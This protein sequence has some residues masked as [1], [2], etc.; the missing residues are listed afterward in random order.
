MRGYLRPTKSRRTTPAVSTV[1]NSAPIATIF[2]R[3][4]SR[5]PTIGAAVGGLT[6]YLAGGD[7][8]STLFGAGAGAVTGAVG[9]YFIAKQKAANGNPTA[10]ADSVYD[11]LNNENSEIDG[12]TG[13]FEKLRDCRLDAARSVKDDLAAHRISRDD[14]QAKLKKIHDWLIE[15][16]DFADALGAKMN[17]RGAAYADASD[18]LSESEPSAKRTLHTRQRTAGRSGSAGAGELVA[19]AAA[20]VREGPS[21]SSRQIASLAPGGAVAT[22]GG[23]DT[24]EGWTHVRL[25]DG[26]S[27]YIASRLLHEAGAG[28]AG[29]PP[30]K[31][32]AGVAQLTESNQLKRKALTEDVADAKSD[33]NG[34]AFQLS[35]SISRVR[36]APDARRA[37]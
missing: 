30:P 29:P 6:G 28:A 8:K 18:K 32:V 10:L 37:A 26:R 31:D 16:I 23:G 35:G 20:R 1:S 19:S 4:W 25:G 3:P 36:P 21:T 14:A 5:A 34:S 2:S 15:D 9:A 33:A 22:L 27:G 12:V 11:D 13:T 24:P 17:E 7:A